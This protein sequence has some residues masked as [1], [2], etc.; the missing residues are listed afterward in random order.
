MDNSIQTTIDIIAKI[1][2]DKKQFEYKKR[3]YKSYGYGSYAYDDYDYYYPKSWNKLYG[4]DK[5]KKVSVYIQWKE[6]GLDMDDF[7][8]GNSENEVWGAFFLEHTNISFNDVIDYE[9]YDED[10]YTD[11]INQFYKKSM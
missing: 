6:E 9:V 1:T 11:Y 2:R 10:E 3:E 5:S 4:Y 8:E 7:L